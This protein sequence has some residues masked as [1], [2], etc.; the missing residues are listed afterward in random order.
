MLIS[1]GV[2]WSRVSHNCWAGCASEIWIHRLLLDVSFL[3]EE[4]PQVDPGK[5]TPVRVFW[6]GT[7]GFAELPAVASA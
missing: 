5:R 1:S 3:Y 2:G 4:F 6:A 7:Q